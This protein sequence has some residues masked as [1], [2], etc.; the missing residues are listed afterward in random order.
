MTIRHFINHTVVITVRIFIYVKS[1][2]VYFTTHEKIEF[3]KPFDGNAEFNGHI[4]IVAMFQKNLCK[5]FE[6]ML[7]TL[8]RK[9]IKIVAINNLNADLESTEKIKNL[10]DIYVERSPGLGRDIAAY[11][12]GIQIINKLKITNDAQSK[13]IFA[14]DSVLYLAARLSSFLDKTIQ[15][16]KKIIGITE[17]SEFHYHISSWFF[18]ISKEVF[19][20][21][22]FQAFW[23]NYKGYQSR[24]H[25][26]DKGE[27]DISRT[28]S[29][30]GL[31][32]HVVYDTNFIINTLKS[33]GTST[34][35]ILKNLPITTRDQLNK[36]NILNTK[37]LFYERLESISNRI[38]QTAYW[39][40]VLLEHFDFP[41]IKKDLYP[42]EIYGLS[43]IKRVIYCSTSKNHKEQAAIEYILSQISNKPQTSNE[44][45]TNKILIKSGVK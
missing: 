44:T 6:E 28:F 16:D 17:T 40:L 35:D 18:M 42:R 5:N 36:K 20:N 31:A 1:R 30:L 45:F 24:R 32:P 27:V 23:K 25:S 41:F 33:N 43:E 2:V 22:T 34:I 8:K 29:K 19:F 3:I 11:K 26:I 9:N 12:L 15:L 13:I 7:A 14:N 4:A 38:N 21:N 37:E 10:V 39:S